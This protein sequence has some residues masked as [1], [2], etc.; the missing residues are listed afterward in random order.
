M[1]IS[2]IIPCYNE[3]KGLPEL[4]QACGNVT[5]QSDKIDI[6]LV[7]NG[8]SDETAAILQRTLK[9]YK[10]CSTVRV[11]QN[12]GY[13]FGILEGLKAAK[14]D[15]IGWT[16]ADL[17]TD[18]N[19]VLRTLPLFEQYGTNIFV[20]GKRYGRP[21]MDVFF[22][23]GMSVFETLLMGKKMWDINAQPTLFPRQFFEQWHQPPHDFSLDLY[24]YY[25]AHH[26]KLPINR[27]LVKFGKRAYGMSHWNVN[28]RAKYKFIRRT[29]D[30]SLKLKRQLKS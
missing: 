14:G 12:Q 19:D 29:I 28:W 18:P 8:S 17:Q 25:Q 15:I 27:F 16:H 11:A 20:K 3:A 13:G 22:T 26:Q 5:A 9:N 4:L 30:F 23:F 1:K 7:D 6:I 2:L 24:A 21:L 10:N